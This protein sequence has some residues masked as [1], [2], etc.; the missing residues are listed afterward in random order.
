MQSVIFVTAASSCNVAE[1]TS[2]GRG[3]QPNAYVVFALK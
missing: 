1:N 3:K 2:E